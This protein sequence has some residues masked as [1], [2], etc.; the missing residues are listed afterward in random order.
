MTVYLNET[1]RK[2]WPRWGV[3]TAIPTERAIFH[4]L[5]DLPPGWKLEI[6]LPTEPA[7]AESAKDATIAELMRQV[8]ALRQTVEKKQKAA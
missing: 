4:C 1:T 5:G 8:D 6:P 3:N 2:P 7:A